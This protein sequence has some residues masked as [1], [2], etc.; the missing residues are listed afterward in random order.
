MGRGKQRI[1]KAKSEDE[2]VKIREHAKELIAEDKREGIWLG[3]MLMC[4]LRISEIQNVEIFDNSIKVIGK[5]D[6]E[7]KV[8]TPDWLLEAL[9][10]FK[11]EGR[12]GYKQKK[13]IVDRDLRKLGYEKFHSLRHTFA[14]ILLKRGVELREIQKLLGHA[15]ISTTQIYARTQINEE[16]TKVLDN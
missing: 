13:Q 8:P 15:S 12:D 9:M 2:F 3:L 6:K 4:G 1:P 16:T 11:A 7:R 10:E 5:G 14:T